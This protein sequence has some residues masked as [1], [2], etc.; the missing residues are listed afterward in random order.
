MGGLKNMKT[1]EV[2]AAI[3][4]DSNRV[5]ATQR[6]YGEFEGW[7]EFPGGKIEQGESHHEAL[8]REIR[9]ELAV[10]IEVGERLCT[11]EYDYPMFHLTMHCYMASQ[12]D[13]DIALLEHKAARWLTKSELD[14]VEW[15]PADVSIVDSLRSID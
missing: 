9:E 13:G 12:L 11:V 8:K 3:I 7:W 4:C 1:I 15:L 2:V 10:E 14:E 6:G 5:F